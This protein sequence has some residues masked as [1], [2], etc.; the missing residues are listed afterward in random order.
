MTIKDYI[1]FNAEIVDPMSFGGKCQQ[2]DTPLPPPPPVRSYEEMSRV[3]TPLPPPPRSPLPTPLSQIGMYFVI[4]MWLG[5]YRSMLHIC[6]TYTNALSELS[7]A[8][9]PCV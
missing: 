2:W 3:E 1:R 4:V 5:N 7:G 6:F 8:N 9:I